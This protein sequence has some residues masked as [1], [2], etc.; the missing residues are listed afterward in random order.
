MNGHKLYTD[1]EK[2]IIRRLSPDY[3]AICKLIPDRDRES[4]RSMASRLSVTRGKHVFTAAEI[5]RLRRLY[6]RSPWEEL[7]AAFPS[8]TRSQL[9]NAAKYHGFHRVRKPYKSTGN[10]PLDQLLERLQAANMHLSDLDKEFRTK[11]YFRNQNWR[12]QPPNYNR[13][14]KAIEL[15]EGKLTIKWDE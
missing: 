2:E 13:F 6:P 7:L 8:L 15:L 1:A 5:S 14:V 11:G 4:I 3:D 9:K 10:S 12:Y